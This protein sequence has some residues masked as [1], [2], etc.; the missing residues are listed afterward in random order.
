MSC[1]T[2]NINGKPYTVCTGEIPADTS[3]NT[4][5]RNHA[6]L[7]GT[8]LMCNEGGCGVCIVTLKRKNPLT[9]K[10]ETLA[11]N[12]C[13][14]PLYACH[15]DDVITVEGIGNSKNGY[16]LEQTRLLK[17]NGS[18]CGYCSPGMIMNMHSLLE[19]DEGMLTMAKVENSFG[20]NICRCTGYRPIL[21]AFKSLAVDADSSLLCNDIEDL[22]KM[23]TNCSVACKKIMADTLHLKFKDGS[24]WHKVYT[25]AQVLQI[26][27]DATLQPYIL[28]AGNTARGVYRERVAPKLFID[29][30]DVSDL[31]G[32]KIVDN[33]LVIGAT[34]SLTDTIKIFESVSQTPGFEYCSTLAQHIDL[35]ANVPVRNIGTIGGNLSIKHQHNSFPSDMFLM[36]E[37]VGA[38]LTII[39]A[40]TNTRSLV[41]VAEFLT[42]D[43]FKKLIVNVKLPMLDRNLYKFKSYKIMIR[44]QNAHAYVN[45][46]FLLKFK[47]N[48]V[49]SARICFGGI[50]PK[51]IHAS[52]TESF[53]RGKNL[54][55][56]ETL[57]LAI[58]VLKNE[59]QPDEVIPDASP[60][61]RKLLAVSLFYKF[62]LR[63]C[64]DKLIKP[65]HRSG[66]N[67]L[68]RPLSGGTQTFETQENK[69]PL[70]EPIVK[71]EGLAQVSGTAKYANDIPH[72]I[73]ELWAAFVTA[74][75]VHSK[76][77]KVDATEALKIPG[78]RHFFSA[79]DIPGKNNFTPTLTHFIGIVE[80]EKIFIEHKGEVLFH[81][82]P[83]GIILAETFALA[84][85]A[86]TKVKVSYL[87]NDSYV[88]KARSFFSPWIGE[89]TTS[90][91]IRDVFNSKG[92]YQKIA[93]T[94]ES[95]V[96]GA[97][98]TINGTIEL[99]GQYHMHMEPQTTMCIPTETGMLVH[100][101]N[102]WTDFTQ[103]AIAQCL[104]V[105]ENSIHI[106][107]KRVGGAFGGKVTRGA[108]IAC[109]CA[110]ACHLTD[111][112]V[113]F[114][115]TL[116]SNMN[117]VGKRNGM[118]GEY[119]IDVD[120]NGKI[121]KVTGNTA[122]DMG[123][124]LNESPRIL[125]DVAYSN[126]YDASS[127]KLTNQLIT[128]DAPSHTWCRAPGT[129]EV[130]AMAETMMEHIARITG[131]DPLAVRVANLTSDTKMK[132]L[133]PK[134]VK[135]IEYNDR[136]D[137]ICEFNKKNRWNKRGIAIS[138][139]R[140]PLLYFDT[141]TAY[142]C[143]YHD[144][145][146][147]V[148]KHSGVEI[149]Q[150]LNTKITQVAA[151]TLGIPHTFVTVG[152]TDT[153]IGANCAVTGG[154]VA[155]EIICFTVMKACEEIMRR[156][157]PLRDANKDAQWTDLTKEAY[158][159]QIGLSVAH[160]AKAA[161]L[162]PYDVL[163]LSCAEIE[164]DLLTGNLL[165]H[166]VDILEDAGLS[167]NPLIDVGQVEGAFVMGMS[168]WLTEA[169]IYD[170][171]NGELMTNRTWTY[172]PLGAKDIPIDFRV[173]LLQNSINSVFVLGS[174]AVGEPALTMSVVVNFALRNALESARRDAGITN[175]PWFRMPSPSTPEVIALCAGHS[176][177]A[178]TL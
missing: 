91:T 82:Q 22:P 45:A 178:F 68:Q 100:S 176:T 64:D 109:A 11:V 142:V 144:D 7:S 94:T 163:G 93:E 24:E 17:K 129:T 33:E 74:T 122:H 120:D 75:R 123:C 136:K 36:L 119:T 41:E 32:H 83:V 156:L 125:A 4:Y 80:E 168:Y 89:K 9:N 10:L 174:K 46:G 169:L 1:I 175:D 58:K 57:Q 137:K 134:F 14:M 66:G 69:F 140:Y 117:V 138:I 28:L 16:C 132:D 61:Y 150:G 127:W 143:V 73:N 34:N 121:L 104:N 53:L 65:V 39:D 128:T 92:K 170:R 118:I 6:Q 164:V 126:C 51:F 155:S 160:T 112:P 152:S 40:N 116:E 139:M 108:Q 70:T 172:K 88:A 96:L 157:Q 110:L 115:M 141:T 146:T 147:V 162:K 49:E 63:T 59:L 133:I 50:N 76:L 44:A 52:D 13:L 90:P 106:E 85:L 23:H 47:S 151:H 135:D 77:D 87:E 165:V 166:R 27:K 35:I 30:N 2:F 48:I 101:S 3:L 158:K 102:Q 113:R 72:F 173:T 95:Q 5:L 42:V 149:G 71:L 43:M 130:I 86:A 145:G 159:N 31:R 18:Q 98:K 167:L 8:K 54:Y 177:D 107:V 21:D 111:V 12:S 105:Q 153:I 84:N 26:L 97:T 38:K 60:Q 15:N 79:L 20:G 103:T 161:D 171:M 56:N 37:S 81:G 25:I 131:K 154:S 124:S 55:R 62:V 148:V 99:V 78:V 114:A 19:S 29:I 67:I